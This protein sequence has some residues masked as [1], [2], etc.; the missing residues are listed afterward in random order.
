[1]VSSPFGPTLLAA[2]FKGRNDNKLKS[3]ED[4]ELKGFLGKYGKPKYLWKPQAM[5]Y[6][7]FI[8]AI[9]VFGAHIS[10]GVLT[11]RPHDLVF[12]RAAKVRVAKN[13]ALDKDE[14]LCAADHMAYY[15]C[16]AERMEF[17]VNHNFPLGSHLL[18]NEFHGELQKTEDYPVPAHPAADY[19]AVVEAYRKT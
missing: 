16:M 4:V 15:V 17:L 6:A 13:G 12:T 10:F 7:G 14:L 2:D 1:M 9:A 18:F 11:P 3:L 19:P 5:G 8:P